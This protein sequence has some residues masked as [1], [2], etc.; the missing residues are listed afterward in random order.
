MCGQIGKLPN[1][2]VWRA[3]D[4]LGKLAALQLADL[5]LRLQA[6]GPLRRQR[7][8]GGVLAAL[9]AADELAA[10]LQRLEDAAG[11]GS[12]SSSGA[13]DGSAGAAAGV[14]GD[15]A[16]AAAADSSGSAAEGTAEA[17]LPAYRPWED[18]P[19]APALALAA[20]RSWALAAWPAVLQLPQGQ[21]RRAP[22]RQR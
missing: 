2:R 22:W 17:D 18:E 13:D 8:A 3:G 6:A 4:S 10:A 7:L 15:M 21:E 11:G 20:A 1:E 16:A 19:I 12:N 9:A 5:T 14:A